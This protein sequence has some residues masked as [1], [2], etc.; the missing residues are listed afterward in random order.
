MKAMKNNEQTPQE[1]F[2]EWVLNIIGN[3]INKEICAMIKS[4]KR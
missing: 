2:N 4:K 3:Q 1:I